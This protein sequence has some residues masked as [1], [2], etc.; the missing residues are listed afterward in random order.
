MYIGLIQHAMQAIAFEEFRENKVKTM[1]AEDLDRQ[2]ISSHGIN[3]TIGSGRC[4]Q[5]GW[6][7][8]P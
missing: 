2:I 1:V 8:N 7:C 4:D 5:W 3:C 6:I